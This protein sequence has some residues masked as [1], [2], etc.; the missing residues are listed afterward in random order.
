[1]CG[2]TYAEKARDF[3]GKECLD[4]EDQGTRTQ[5]NDSA[6][7]FVGFMV[8]RLVSGCLWPIILTQGP[9]CGADNAQARQIP[10]RTVGG[11]RRCGISFGPFPNSSGWAWLVSSVFLTG[12]SYHKITHAN[13]ECG[14]WPG[15][16]FWA[17]CFPWQ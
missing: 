5:E 8:M 6:L 9:S 16:Q 10:S 11:G 13:R 4:R 12:T 2:E 3:I 1:M 14:A 7:W 15:G 17:V